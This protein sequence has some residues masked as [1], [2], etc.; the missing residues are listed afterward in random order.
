MTRRVS[1]PAIQG[2]TVFVSSVSDFP[3]AVGGVITL[4]DDRTYFLTTNVDLLG[5][6]IVTGQNSVMIGGSSENCILSSTG[7]ASGTALVSSAWSFP[8]RFMAF[9]HGTALNLDATGNANQA[10]DWFGVNFLNCSTIGTIKNYGNVILTSMAWLNSEGLTIDGT[11]GTVS[12]DKCLVQS[13]SGTALSLASTA[14]ITRRFRIFKSSVVAGAPGSTGLDVSTSATIPVESYQLDDVNFAGSGT[15]AAGV[16]HDDNKSLWINCKGVENSASTGL[17]TMQGNA[18]ATTITTQGVA[19]KAAGTTTFQSSVS[20]RFSHTDNR[21][22]YTGAITRRFKVSIVASMLA[23]NNTQ[24]GSYIAKNGS[25]VSFSEIYTTADGNNR[26]ENTAIQAIV[27]LAQN[28][29][30]E[31]WIEN[32]SGT[33]AV[34]VE[35]LTAIVQQI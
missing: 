18:T 22:T 26:S 23:S 1:N 24:L 4:A 20:Q 5:A 12:L 14:T 17:M 30:I 9:N 13:V 7:L 6:R 29:Y 10:L 19:V 21:L 32:D 15:R 33:N 3:A 35:D 34:T 8:C 2:D 31:F 16:Q 27:E 28:D 11:I 25:L